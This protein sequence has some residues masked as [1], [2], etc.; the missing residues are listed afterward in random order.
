MECC[1]RED[2]R[3]ER[4]RHGHIRRTRDLRERQRIAVRIG[5]RKHLVLARPLAHRHVRGLREHRRAVGVVD[6]QAGEVAILRERVD[7]RGRSARARHGRAAVERDRAVRAVAELGQPRTL[8]FA[9]Q[10]SAPERR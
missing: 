9:D 3:K 6:R 7:V 5:G 1:G 10:R 8:R 2:S 4:R